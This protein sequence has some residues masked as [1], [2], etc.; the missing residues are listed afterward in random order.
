MKRIFTLSLALSALLV[1]SFS[2]FAQTCTPVVNTSCTGITTN[3]ATNSSG[4]TGDF[5]YIGTGDGFLQSSTNGAGTTKELV[6]PTYVAPATGAPI[7]VRFDL[8]GT[9]ATITNLT[10]SARTTTGD[11]V[12]CT[13][14]TLN[15][16]VNCFQFATPATL[17]NR[18]FRLVYTFTVQGGNPAN[19][20]IEFDDFGTNVAAS[21]TPLPVKF[22]NLKAVKVGQQVEIS[23]PNLTEKNVLSYSIERSANGQNFAQIG[24]IATVKNNEGEASYSYS[25]AAPLGAINIYRIKCTEAG[26]KVAYSTIVKVDIGSKG[27]SLVLAPNPSTGSTLGLQVS[28]LP[29]GKYTVKIFNATAQVVGGE[30]I[31]H[32]GGS[33]SQTIALNN[34]KPGL[35]YF[36]L[37]GPANLKKQF[38]VQ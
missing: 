36:D 34:L 32:A 11:I 33:I 18:P 31:Q 29:A 24:E 6:S 2:S 5:S 38:I 37:A 22:A 28:N 9:N 16:G 30:T 1:L 7:N 21:A 19:R 20:V 17:A 8:T 10:I 27:L 13:G 35:Y 25:D 23:F 4:F 12:L 26:G 14:S 15:T 3:F